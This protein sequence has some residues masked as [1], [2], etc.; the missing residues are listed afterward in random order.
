MINSRQEVR[1]TQYK[2]DY[3]NCLGYNEDET[4]SSRLEVVEGV[5][6]RLQSSEP[7][8]NVLISCVV[9]ACMCGLETIP[10]KDKHQ[11][12]GQVYIK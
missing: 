10:Q 3:I 11:D 7:K 9:A 8:G 6:G 1:I 12:K 5:T 4:R 2:I